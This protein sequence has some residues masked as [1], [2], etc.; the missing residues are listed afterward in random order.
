M[1]SDEFHFLQIIWPKVSFPQL[2]FQPNF[3]LAQWLQMLGC[4]FDMLPNLC[5]IKYKALPP[6][7][8]PRKILQSFEIKLENLERTRNMFAE[9]VGQIK[10][11]FVKLP[12]IVHKINLISAYKNTCSRSAFSFQSTTRNGV[13]RPRN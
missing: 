13:D 9:F 11:D 10:V 4:N 1:F 8:I 6:A 7:P 3:H 12:F 5:R 2:K